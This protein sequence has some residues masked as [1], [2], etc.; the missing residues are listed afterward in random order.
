[1]TTEDNNNNEAPNVFD[2]L[3]QLIGMDFHMEIKD[4]VFCITPAEAAIALFSATA[5][6]LANM[7][8]VWDEIDAANAKYL[9]LK[10]RTD[11]HHQLLE[12]CWNSFI[13]KGFDNEAR[14]LEDYLWPVTGVLED[15]TEV[16]FSSNDTFQDFLD[17]FH[18]YVKGEEE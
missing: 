5:A 16:D 12:A 10:N 2:E 3:K 8:N 13:V 14:I 17:G 1:M 6:T 11:E 15:G 9:E 7:E 18:K 4:G